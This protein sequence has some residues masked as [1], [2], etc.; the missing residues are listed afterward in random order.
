MVCWLAVQF[1]RVSIYAIRSS[2][3]VLTDISQGALK[4]DAV[5]LSRHPAPVQL[6]QTAATIVGFTPFADG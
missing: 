6:R 2:F 1:V 5:R 3:G 4:L